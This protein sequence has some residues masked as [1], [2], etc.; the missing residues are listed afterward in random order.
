MQIQIFGRERLNGHYG[1]AAYVFANTVSSIPYLFL[2]SVVPGAIAYYLVG[3]QKGVDH[4]VYFILI[5]FTCTLLVESIMMIIASVVPDFLMGIIVGCGIQGIMQLNA[6]FF[7]LPNDLP[8]PVW[9]FP[10][11][12]LAY[13]KYAN[14]GLYRN[15]YEG[16]TFPNQA[17]GAPRIT[18][19]DILKGVWQ[20][21]MVYSKWV[22]LFILMGMV[23]VYRLVFFGIIKTTEKMKPVIR[24]LLANRAKQLN[25]IMVETSSTPI[26]VRG[27]SGLN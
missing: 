4:F 27:E 10:V 16:L 6:G 12:Y 5:I 26:H 2:N 22:D 7:R 11:Y 19:D 1:V 21:H 3:L 14:E 25:T 23:V 18:S 24:N 13:H 17:G 15:E 8:N 9:K 20:M